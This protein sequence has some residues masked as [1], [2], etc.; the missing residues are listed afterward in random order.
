MTGHA[1]QALI[2]DET[3]VASLS[4]QACEN[5]AP[6]VHA[7]TRPFLEERV[8]VE[9]LFDFGSPKIGDSFRSGGLARIQGVY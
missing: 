1:F 5:R 7:A 3:A 2:D 9:F 4:A 6:A 8:K